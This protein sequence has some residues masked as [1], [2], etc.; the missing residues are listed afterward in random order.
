[1]PKF[2]IERNIPGIGAAGPGDL[3]DASRKSNA[4]LSDLGAQIQWVHSY[5][6]DDKTYCVYLAPSRELIEEH[7]T[8]SGFPANRI[9]EVKSLIAPTT[10]RNAA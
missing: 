5:V 7:A 1:M 9:A 6:T 10:A 8:R 2:I 4:V 3:Q